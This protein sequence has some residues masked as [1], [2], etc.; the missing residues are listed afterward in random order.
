MIDN[1]IKMIISSIIQLLLFT[2][3]LLVCLSS[4]SDFTFATNI[5]YVDTT[6]QSIQLTIYFFSI[7]FFLVVIVFNLMELFFKRPILKKIIILVSILVWLL[8]LL[9]DYAT[10][11][12]LS[13]VSF[14]I[15]T[16]C[17]LSKPFIKLKI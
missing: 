14:I 7:V 11:P 10:C 16:I 4:F 8:F 13:I 9:E 3:L 2:L 6:K 1:S 15:G 12:K 17:L 5:S